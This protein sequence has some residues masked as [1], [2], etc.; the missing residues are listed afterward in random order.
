MYLLL[1]LFLKVSTLTDNVGVSNKYN[2]H[3]QFSLGLSCKS[4]AWLFFCDFYDLCMG[5]LPNIFL[6]VHIISVFLIII[7]GENLLHPEKKLFKTGF[8]IF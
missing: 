7:L 5:G 8:A 3:K 1:L 4:K 2:G 6:F